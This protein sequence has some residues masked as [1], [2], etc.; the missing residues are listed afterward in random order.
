LRA[1][2]TRATGPADASDTPPALEQD[3]VGTLLIEDE[4]GA[5]E[6]ICRILQILETGEDFA[7]IY[8]ALCADAPATRAGAREL[9][10][11][12]LSGGCRDGLLALTDS[13][14]PPQRLEAAAKA[15]PVPLAERSLAAWQAWK[16]PTDEQDAE[17]MLAAVVEEL[18]HDRNV[19][20]ASVA[21]YET[22]GHGAPVASTT[23]VERVAS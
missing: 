8:A 17:A 2:S 14:P 22:R 11:H 19:V 6:R 23:E 5:L 1:H 18:C 4:R 20:L 10:G 7:T 16:K 9:I 3:L 13:L 15:M 12:V 21:Q